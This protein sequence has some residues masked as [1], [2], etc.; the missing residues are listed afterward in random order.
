[1]QQFSRL[2]LTPAK[3]S[4]QYGGQAVS[5]RFLAPQIPSVIF[6]Q[7]YSSPKRRGMT[8]ARFLGKIDGPFICLTAAMLCHSLRCWR[9]GIF[10][11][12]VVFT[13]SNAGGKINRADLWFS[14][15]SGSLLA[16]ASGYSRKPQVLETGDK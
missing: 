2:S 12:K 5:L 14:G 4:I 1:V 13:R 11:D 9:T 16:K 10:I 6:A 3:K 7:F 15:V 8:D